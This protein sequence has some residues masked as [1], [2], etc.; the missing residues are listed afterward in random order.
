MDNGISSVQPVWLTLNCVISSKLRKP[1]S[2]QLLH[3]SLCSGCH[4]KKSQLVLCFKYLEKQQVLVTEDFNVN[5]VN[6]KL[7]IVD[8]ICWSYLKM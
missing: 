3:T 4:G 6:H 5:V 7:M 2:H 1:R 8:Q